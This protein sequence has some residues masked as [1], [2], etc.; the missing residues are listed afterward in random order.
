MIHLR[1]LTMP[2][3]DQPTL[4]NPTN[5]GY[6]NLTGDTRNPI[7]DHMVQINA[8]Y[9]AETNPDVTTTGKNNLLLIRS[10]TFV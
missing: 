1:L 10:L 5:H 4:Y 8:E 9:V 3:T 2:Q 6:F 7:D